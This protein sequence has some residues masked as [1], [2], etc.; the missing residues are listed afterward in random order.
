MKLYDSGARTRPQDAVL[1]TVILDSYLPSSSLS[2]DLER[3]LLDHGMVWPNGVHLYRSTV[4]TMN[5]S[6]TMKR[7]DYFGA[8]AGK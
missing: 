4:M 2:N 1:G 6:S 8:D 7:T 3:I 5:G